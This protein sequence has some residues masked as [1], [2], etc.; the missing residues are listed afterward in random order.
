MAFEMTQTNLNIGKKLVGEVN[1]SNKL[2]PSEDTK[3]IKILKTAGAV[4]VTSVEMLADGF[5]VSG[6]VNVSAAFIDETGDI[7]NANGEFDFTQKIDTTLTGV[8][9]LARVIDTQ[10]RI[11]DDAI[12]VSNVIEIEAFGHQ[13]STL[14]TLAENEDIVARTTETEVKSVAA[15]AASTF[16]IAE[17][18]ALNS[19]DEEIELV[20]ADVLVSEATSAPDGVTV[21]GACIVKLWVKTETGFDEIAKTFD[22]KQE[23]DVLGATD[24]QTASVNLSVTNVSAAIEDN[25]DEQ[26]QAN[27][28]VDVKAV[29]F[30][31]ED[32]A[33]T[34]TTD[35]FSCSGEL[36]LA[37]EYIEATQVGEAQMLTDNIVYGIGLED[38]PEFDAIKLVTVTGVP[39]SQADGE[40]SGNINLDVIFATLDG[41]FD[42]K[43]AQI[44][45][46]LNSNDVATGVT[47][48]VSSFKIRGTS[49]LEVIL[50]VSAQTYKEA[51]A[52]FSFVSSAELEESSPDEAGV[53]MIVAKEDEDLFDICR[54]LKVRPEML[55]A[56]NEGLEEVH[57]GDKIFV[58]LPEIVNF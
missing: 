9:F 58:Y 46:T 2:T 13:E 54:A 26:K 28:T 48:V 49:E 39:F 17:D 25:G 47:A 56:Q 43:A 42:K 5:M 12:F 40:I 44:P 24:G 34:L 10:A 6:K 45:F 37:T 8:E 36:K 33:I 21:N 57:A 14:S 29:A 15:V 41:G 18:I 3:P 16:T 19:G 1:V 55:K 20:S 31:L 32:K 30:T 22:F 23:L 52:N 35:A 4:S 50:N 7:S 27:I 38:Y 11:A 53:K 51:K